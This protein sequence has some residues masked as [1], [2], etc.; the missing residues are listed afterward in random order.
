MGYGPYISREIS[1]FR[2]SPYAAITFLLAFFLTLF[3]SEVS[4]LVGTVA[5]NILLIFEPGLAFCGFG[6]L[7]SHMLKR[8]QRRGVFFVLLLAFA[9]TF[10]TP[11]LILGLAM[12][13]ACAILFSLI[14]RKIGL[15][16]P[17]DP[18][19]AQS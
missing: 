8:R 5:E 9:A 2:M 11:V 7:M 17:Q 13:G 6:T 18:P 4:T 10:L 3:L 1:T 14:T 12:Y 19:K 16:G 15:H